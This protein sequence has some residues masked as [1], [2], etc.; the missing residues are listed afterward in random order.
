MTGP[1]PWPNV[2]PM[3]TPTCP[4]PELS[5]VELKPLMQLWRLGSWDRDSTDALTSS[6]LRCCQ[7]S[8]TVLSTY[9][10]PGTSLGMRAAKTRDT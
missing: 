6:L 9:Y 4:G 7:F 5:G 10:V 2:L 1:L 8:P 3:G